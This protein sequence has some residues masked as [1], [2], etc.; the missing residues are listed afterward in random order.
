MGP[1]Q[2]GK[3]GLVVSLSHQMFAYGTGIL[4]DFKEHSAE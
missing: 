2:C 4:S 1:I 3:V